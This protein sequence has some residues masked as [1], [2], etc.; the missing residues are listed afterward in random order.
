MGVRIAQAQNTGSSGRSPKTLSGPASRNRASCTWARPA[1]KT[2]PSRENE[3][4]DPKIAWRAVFSPCYPLWAVGK[5]EEAVKAALRTARGMYRA[6]PGAPAT[7][8]HAS[9][10][11][12]RSGP[13]TTPAAPPPMSAPAGETHSAGVRQ[14]RHGVGPA[15]PITT[16]NRPQNPMWQRHGRR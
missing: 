14:T 12:N 11:R 7:P 15:P 5:M 6:G 13:A 10:P 1:L 8:C 3:P 16:T 2:T 9:H 4:G